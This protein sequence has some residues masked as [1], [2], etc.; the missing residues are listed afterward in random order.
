LYGYFEPAILLAEKSPF[1]GN[2]YRAPMSE[3]V[4]NQGD[5]RRYYMIPL[6]VPPIPFRYTIPEVFYSCS[7][8]VK[9]T[10]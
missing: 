3:L 6:L 7:N 4:K 2:A 10:F 5:G 8:P 9:P 1:I